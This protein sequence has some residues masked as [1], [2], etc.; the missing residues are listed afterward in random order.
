ML[1]LKITYAQEQLKLSCHSPG[2][3][4]LSLGYEDYRSF[5]RAFKS[6][7]GFSPSDYQKQ[8]SPKTPENAVDE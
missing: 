1:N 5:S 6:R 4:A 3:I 7:T 2:E 8:Y